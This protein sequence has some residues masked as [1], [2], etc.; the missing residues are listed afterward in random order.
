[1]LYWITLIFS[2][3]VLVIS[4]FFFYLKKRDNMEK[5]NFRSNDIYCVCVFNMSNYFLVLIYHAH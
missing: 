3:V 4:L 2:F 5:R 1:M